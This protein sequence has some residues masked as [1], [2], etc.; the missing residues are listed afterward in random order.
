M[1]STIGEDVG[2]RV[3]PDL[4]SL[5]A[6]ELA[7][8]FPMIEDA[9]FPAFMRD[10]A[11]HGL[12]DEIVLLNGRILDGRNRYKALK[13]L[14]WE[15]QTH[16][17]VQF[18][19]LLK[20]KGLNQTPFAFVMSKNEKRRHLTE[21]QRA[22][23]AAR[24]ATMRQ[25][26]RTDIKPL[27]IDPEPSANVRKVSQGEAAELFKVSER[28]VSAANRVIVDGVAELRELVDRGKVAVSVAEQIARLAPE[29]QEKAM[30]ENRP[31]QLKNV[32]KKVQRE[33]RARHLAEKQMALPVK[34]Y[35]IIY[36]DPEWEFLVRSEGGMDR[37]AANHYPVSPIE[38]LMAR[39]V[40]DIA[41][42]DCVLFMWATVPMLIEAIMVADAWGFCLLG[43]DPATGFM[44]V[45]KR[46]CRYVS[47]WD[48]VKTT[49]GNGYWN[50]NQ[51]EHL[52]IFT[53]GNPVAPA[54]GTQPASAISAPVGIGFDNNWQSHVTGPELTDPAGIVLETQEHSFK[55]AKFAEWIERLFPDA[56]K[57]EL[58]ARQARPGW[59][60]WGNE[61]PAEDADQAAD[62]PKLRP[63]SAGEKQLMADIR[64]DAAAMA[65]EEWN[66]A[67]PK[68][69]A[70]PFDQMKDSVPDINGRPVKAGMTVFA[71]LQEETGRCEYQVRRVYKNGGISIDN[72]R[73]HQVV[74]KSGEFEA[75]ET[76]AEDKPE[77]FKVV[78]TFNAANQTRTEKARYGDG[79]ETHRYYAADGTLLKEEPADPKETVAKAHAR[80][81]GKPTAWE[82]T[83]KQ[84]AHRRA[85]D[86]TMLKSIGRDLPADTETLTAEYRLAVEKMNAAVIAGDHDQVVAARDRQRA[87]ILKCNDWE[88]SGSG[89]NEQ[90]KAIVAAASAREGVLG[91]PLFGQLACFLAEENG[92][93][94]IVKLGYY[95]DDGTS[96]NIDLY[97]SLAGRPFISETG[98][99][100]CGTIKILGKTIDQV[101]REAIA[102]AIRY[103]TDKKLNPYGKGL[104]VPARVHAINA[105]GTQVAAIEP[106][107]DLDELQRQDAAEAAET[108]AGAPAGEDMGNA[109][110][111]KGKGNAR[112]EAA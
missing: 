4:E 90:A 77:A 16:Y 11:E 19:D 100:G 44:T 79:R 31:D 41:A 71:T 85:A 69:Q 53:R 60:R 98:Y 26:E 66:A 95:S 25:G 17:Y 1:T 110:T 45:D 39:R 99:M 37:A 18:E 107:G 36:A 80:F 111:R 87:I 7:G 10:I 34:K 2:G 20:A 13:H 3:N 52:L 84:I 91:M 23:A 61:A 27:P 65:E 50:R 40:E 54:L 32:V 81:S 43:R 42:P 8:I 82:K 33:E 51:H 83:E 57:I 73:G 56:P 47:N 86:L 6:H 15:K 63:M 96:V 48:W 46:K 94:A 102:Y 59:D 70:R 103:A 49:L 28:L 12:T 105:L 106:G 29:A 9:D 35:G 76:T 101:G 72:E 24:A 78:V 30:T 104:Q 22:M 5:E 92:V 109:R 93:R 55:P 64:A 21:S 38:E 75:E 62:L 108:T 14:G 88:F 68:D 89:V 67:A 97:A 58:N 112:H 74:L